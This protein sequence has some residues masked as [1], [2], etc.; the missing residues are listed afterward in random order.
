MQIEIVTPAPPGSRNGNRVTANRW[1]RLLEELGHQVTVTT[2]WSGAAVDVLVALHARRSAAAVRD[3]AAAH[4]DRPVVVAL[5]GTDLYQDLPDSVEVD[6]SLRRARAAVVLQA[7]ARESVPASLRERV[8]VI[9]QSVTVPQSQSQPQAR[10][11]AQGDDFPVL[12][13]A[14]LRQVK[15]PVLL[16]A[17]TRLLPSRS[18]VLVTHLGAALDP[19]WE[20]WAQAE[21]AANPR[22]R[23]EGDVARSEALRWLAEARLLVL[24]SRMEGGANVVSEAIAVG[25]PVLATRVEGSV[26]LLGEDYPGY[27]AVGDAHGLAALLVRAETDPEFYAELQERV[28][29]L[30]HLVDPARERQAWAELLA[31]V[32]R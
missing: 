10:V 32:A 27:V 7:R 18:R 12:F 5:T 25:T 30:R 1:A 6:Q 19:E 4:P 28:T 24:T 20:E 31:E 2:A 8:H 23:W 29:G 3:F 14:H 15:D 26:G 11:P 13:L 21:M 16:S 17:A 9:H 22:Y